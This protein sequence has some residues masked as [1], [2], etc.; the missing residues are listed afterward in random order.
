MS[1]TFTA[2]H[3]LPNGKELTADFTMSDTDRETVEHE[4]RERKEKKK[5]QD[6]VRIASEYAMRNMHGEYHVHCWRIHA[7]P[8]TDFF[9]YMDKQKAA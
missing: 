5:L 1:T 2:I 3:V 7:K 6:P 9:D 4:E 8:G